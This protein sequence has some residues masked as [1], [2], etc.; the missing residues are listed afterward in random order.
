MTDTTTI[1]ITIGIAFNNKDLLLQALTHSTYARSLGNPKNHN[2]W[3]A[4]FGDTLLELIA[5]DYLYQI[6]TDTLQK[7][8]IC[9]K[10]NEQVSDRKLVEFAEQIGLVN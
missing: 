3:L 9:Q 7:G 8:F 5:V 4:L 10:R 2:E 1:E 6:S